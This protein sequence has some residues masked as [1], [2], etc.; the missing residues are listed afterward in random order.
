MANCTVSGTLHG[1]PNQ[2]ATFELVTPETVASSYVA[3]NTLYTANTDGSG[4]FSISLPR[5]D[6]GEALY[7]TRRQTGRYEYFVVRADDVTLD[8]NQAVHYREDAEA[9]P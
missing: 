6:S 9:R 7:R 8:Y 5:P 3:A 2:V 1:Y 4:L